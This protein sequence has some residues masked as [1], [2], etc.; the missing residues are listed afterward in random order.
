MDQCK[1]RG[2]ERQRKRIKH[3]ERWNI[4][5]LKYKHEIIIID[6]GELQLYTI[7]L[8]ET[9]MKGSRMETIDGFVHFYS[10][11]PI[12]KRTR[13]EISL[14]WRRILSRNVIDWKSQ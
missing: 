14:F 3:L 12:E 9:K 6:L 10:G 8:S 11:I 13:W 4:Q 7:I 5:G 1:G 2:S